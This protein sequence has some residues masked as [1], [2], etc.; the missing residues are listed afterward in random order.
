MSDKLENGRTVYRLTV[1]IDSVDVVNGTEQKP[2]T[3][4]T[5]GIEGEFDNFEDAKKAMMRLSG[6]QMEIIES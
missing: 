3:I 4:S 6:K 1:G 5:V 2:E